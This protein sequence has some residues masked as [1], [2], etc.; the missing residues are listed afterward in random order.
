MKDGCI[1]DKYDAKQTLLKSMIAEVSEERSE[2][3]LDFQLSL[4]VEYAANFWLSLE[5][6]YASRCLGKDVVVGLLDDEGYVDDKKSKDAGS[7]T[8]FATQLAVEHDSH[9][10]MEVQVN[11]N[12]E[13]EPLQVENLLVS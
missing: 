11:D 12:K 10:L 9:D 7:T 1:K 5:A 3:R 6:E 2:V 13:N 8:L 4:E